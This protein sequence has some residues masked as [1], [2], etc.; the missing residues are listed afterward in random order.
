MFRVLA[1]AVL[2]AATGTSDA[3]AASI[4]TFT[5]DNVFG[6]ECGKGT[7]LPEFCELAVGEL[8]LG[9]SARNNDFSGD[10]EVG[11][12]DIDVTATTPPTVPNNIPRNEQQAL[13]PDAAAR[14]FTLTYDAS[15]GN[16]SL[17]V[18]NVG[19]GGTAVTASQTVDLEGVTDSRGT[20]AQGLYIRARSNI[21]TNVDNTQETVRLS[22]LSLS[23]TTGT[24]ALPDLGGTSF[25][26]GTGTGIAPSLGPEFLAIGGFDF[27]SSWFLT[28]LITFDY[29]T[30]A[31]G[32]KL[33]R[34]QG[35]SGASSLG[36]TF[37]VADFNPNPVPLPAAA[38]MLLTAVGGLA[39]LRALRRPSGA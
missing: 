11:V 12:R 6:A 9:S 1:L 24:F 38:W 13:F 25:G 21:N 33:S 20:S 28:G 30:G 36:V 14:S 26:S 16:L 34:D 15:L 29:A 8:R 7:T 4:R 22:N 3:D 23:G 18:Q 5:G 32:S 31:N 35:G 19:N 37:K 27:L 17:T 2:V 10:W 39:G